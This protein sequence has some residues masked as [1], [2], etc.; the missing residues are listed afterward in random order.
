MYQVKVRK[1]EGQPLWW[2]TVALLLLL[3]TCYFSASNN[4]HLSCAQHCSP[5]PAITCL[6]IWECFKEM[7]GTRLQT[8]LFFFCMPA[9]Q[10]QYILQLHL[11]DPYCIPAL[12]AAQVISSSWYSI[13]YQLVGEG[14]T[15]A[16]SSVK[17]C[18]FDLLQICD[19]W[20]DPINTVVMLQELCLLHLSVF[21]SSVFGLKLDYFHYRKLFRYLA[22]LM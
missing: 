14:C 6:C 22:Y 7:L 1:E 10:V 21:N 20:Q 8:G 12:H 13:K 15:S 18:C 9:W 16:C 17:V 4:Q 3:W 19:W 5:W 11:Q 2:Q